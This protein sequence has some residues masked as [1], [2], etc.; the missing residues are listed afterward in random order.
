MS[1][2]LY[3]SIANTKERPYKIYGNNKLW[4]NNRIITGE[5]YYNLFI[6]FFSYFI[7]YILSIIFFPKLGPLSLLLNIIY[8]IFSS[9]FFVLSTYYM[10]KCGCTDPGI[11]PKQIE[12]N[13]YTVKKEKI[14]YKINGHIY[15]LNYCYSC[16]IFRP[17]RTSHC[18]RCD[19]C[20]E[21]FD[22]HCLWLA[23]CIGK[24]NYK[25]FYAFLLN[26]NLNSIFQLIFCVYVV[27]LESKKIKNNENKGYAFIIIIG[28][29]VLYNVLFLIIFIGKFFA[30]YTFLLCKNMTYSEH[31]KNKFKYYPQNLN[32]F[33]K[34]NICSNKNILCLKRDKSRILDMIEK[35][36]NHDSII[37]NKKYKSKNEENEFF[38]YK[39]KNKNKV[40]LK[41]NK[42]III[43][44]SIDLSRAKVKLFKTY[45]SQYQ[46]TDCKKNF[47]RNEIMKKE[48]NPLTNKN[49]NKKKLLNFTPSFLKKNEIFF[50][51]EGEGIN[52]YSDANLEKQKNLRKKLNEENRNSNAVNLYKI[53]IPRGNTF[54]SDKKI[55]FTNV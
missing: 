23:N 37:I 8:I 7:P 31:K 29:I 10:L 39:N 43:D 15:V 9:V 19:N 47:S 14:K 54:I 5:K 50:D 30:Q 13:N 36:E 28:W 48:K 2:Q 33:N 4:C 49:E 12:K 6:T 55:M 24:R 20:V 18:S 22:H 44:N 46:P 42:E 3:E 25:Y 34:F 11:I 17:P 26:L 35:L 38:E 51:K 32:P 21:R 52:Y 40:Q 41:L 1:N 45:Q 16:N 53:K 27:T